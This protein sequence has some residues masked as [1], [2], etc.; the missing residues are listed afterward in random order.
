M[1]LLE[2]VRRNLLWQLYS[3]LPK[4]PNKA[5]CQ[6]FYGRGW[7]DSPAAIA[8]ELLDRGWQVCWI[9]KGE[10][11]S[12]S[13]PPGVLALPLESPKAIWHQCTAGVWIDNCRK[14]AYTPKRGKTCYV[15]TWHGFPL[16]RIE[17]DA[18]DALAPEYNRAAR[19]DSRIADLFLSDS[20]F[21]TELYRRAFWYSGEILE[22]SLPRY[23]VLTAPR[24]D[25][26][27]K[28]CAT[29][30][31]PPEKKLLLYAPTYRHDHG[32]GVYDVDYA[33]AAAALARRFGGEWQILARLHPNI[34]AKAGEL[35]L[36]PTLVRNASHYPDIQELYQAADAL[37]TDYS[38][39]MFD[40][41]FTGKPG[42][43]YVNDRTAYQNDRNFY[44]DLDLLPYA[45]AET[46]GELEQIILGFDEQRQAAAIGDFF[47]EFGFV[48]AGTAAKQTADWLE[49]RREQL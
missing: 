37:L 6:S 24:P 11:E 28:V 5:V 45:R 25:L 4:D 30:G 31:L 3:L 42:F 43:L 38:S 40:Y 32:L 33:R 47:R 29:L 36:D 16:K 1:S 2:K 39:V 34:A 21:M 35:E 18:E 49:K 14:W 26:R 22:C 27:E 10:Q 44:Y 7:S 46:N 17:G 48:P 13:L 8:Q 23:D 20:R 12:K 19:H 15:Q 41:M 9:V